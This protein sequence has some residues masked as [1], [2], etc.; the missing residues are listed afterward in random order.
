MNQGVKRSECEVFK[1]GLSCVEF[2]HQGQRFV[3]DWVSEIEHCHEPKTVP[4]PVDDRAVFVLEVNTVL[5]K[6]AVEKKTFGF[7]KR[8]SGRSASD[9]SGTQSPVGGIRAA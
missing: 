4:Q 7:R 5:D 3:V 2:W 6:M 1:Q 9:D 8:R